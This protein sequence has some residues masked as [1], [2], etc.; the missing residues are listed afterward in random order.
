[1]GLEGADAAVALAARPGDDGDHPREEPDLDRPGADGEVDAGPDEQRD[2]HVGV[3]AVADVSQHAVER[4]HV[5]LATAMV[6]RG[7][8][9]TRA[10]YSSSRTTARGGAARSRAGVELGRPL[11]DDGAHHLPQ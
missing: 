1:E 7:G 5:P 11:E 6:T 8:D 3:Q 10:R 9:A 2:E 4:V